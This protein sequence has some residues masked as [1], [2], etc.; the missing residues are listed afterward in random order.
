MEKNEYEISIQE[1]DHQGRGIGKIENKV[2]FVKNTLPG[3]IVKIEIIKANKSYLEGNVLQYV[4]KSPKRIKET[5]PYSHLCGGCNLRHISYHDELEYKE[6]KV[7]NIVKKYLKE[8]VKI[9]SIIPSPNQDEYRNK[10]TL[11]VNKVI[12]LYQEKTNEIIPIKS[13]RL[14]SEEITNYMIKLNELELDKISKITIRKNLN[15]I[16]LIITANKPLNKN[17]I[18]Q[19][20]INDAISIIIDYDN[21]Y[22]IIK[23]KSYLETTL[24]NIK[25]HIL[26]NAFFQINSAQTINLYDKILEYM[27][28]KS[29]DR[30]LDLYCGIGSISLYISKYVNNILGIEISKESIISANENKQLNNITNAQFITGDAKKVLKN[31]DYKP[32][33]VIVDPPRSGLDRSVVDEIIAMKPNKVIYVSCDPLTLMRD[34]NIFKTSYDIKKIAIVDMF[35]RTY[36]VECVCVMELRQTFEK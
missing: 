18:V 32:S 21:K 6:T 26:P 7:K 4:K 20:F 11:Q 16:M 1:L 33:I 10:L 19:K 36:H 25:Y 30:V 8:E 3:E 24:K 5:C 29:D 13:C 23:G 12:G 28:P 2:V 15:D 9:E 14:F 17:K 35:P 31:I 34:L 22:E 27:N